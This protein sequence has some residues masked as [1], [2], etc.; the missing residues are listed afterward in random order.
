MPVLHN[1]I[2]ARELP[3]S[4]YSGLNI[5]YKSAAVIGTLNDRGSAAVKKRKVAGKMHGANINA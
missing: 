1:N 5:S 3:S 2:V 4:V